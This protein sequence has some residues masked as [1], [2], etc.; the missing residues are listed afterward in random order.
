M[1]RNRAVSIGV[2]LA[3]IAISAWLSFRRSSAG[4]GPPIR[5]EGAR[6][7]VENQTPQSWR[8]VTVTLN[9]YYRGVS[10][11]LE[12]G[13]RLEAPLGSFVSGLGY[14]FDPSRER[15]SRVEVRATDTAGKP[16]ALDWEGR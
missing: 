8:D 3:A 14:R 1:N 13:G 11:A 4:S 6:L 15:V 10:P 2:V 5:V 12:A 9:A 16:V 7:V